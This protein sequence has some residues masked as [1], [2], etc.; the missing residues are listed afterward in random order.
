MKSICDTKT[1]LKTKTFLSTKSICDTKTSRK[2]K[3]V[4]KTKIAL[5]KKATLMMEIVYARMCIGFFAMEQLSMQQSKDLLW[6][7]CNG[8]ALASC[9]DTF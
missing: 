3:T 7:L 2:T 1:S 8:C 6:H 5:K 9:Y 4:L